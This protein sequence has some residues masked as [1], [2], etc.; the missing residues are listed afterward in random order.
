M[1]FSRSTLATAHP[2]IRMPDEAELTHGR[3]PSPSSSGTRLRPSAWRSREGAEHLACGAPSFGDGEIKSHPYL[4]RGSTESIRTAAELPRLPAGPLSREPRLESV[5]VSDQAT[6]ESR[7]IWDSLASGWDKERAFINEI[8]G[9]VTGR[10]HEAMGVRPGDTI[11]ELCAGPGEVGLRLAEQHPE[12][13]V[14][15]TDFAP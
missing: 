12:V 6:D 4:M 8:E 10:M 15:L 7:Q 9:H 1:S 11:L 3:G 2:R 14:L 13:Q 5:P